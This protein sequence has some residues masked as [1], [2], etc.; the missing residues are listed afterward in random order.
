MF[1]RSVNTP[2]SS[3]IRSLPTIIKP[4]PELV[5]TIGYQIFRRTKVEPGIDC[6][7]GQLVWA[8]SCGHCDWGSLC[9]RSI[10]Y[11]THIRELY[12]QTLSEVSIGLLSKKGMSIHTY[13]TE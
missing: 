1:L 4:I 13:N 10:T 3:S 12:S 9:S 8:R 5:E 6:E 7:E 2:S 11:R